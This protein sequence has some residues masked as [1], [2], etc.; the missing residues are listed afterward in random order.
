MEQTFKVGK[1]IPKL[2]K[3]IAAVIRFCYF[4]SVKIVDINGHEVAPF[5]QAE[6]PILLYISHRNGAL[7]G[8]VTQKL[9]ADAVSLVSIQL[10][11]HPILRYFF[12]GIPVIRDKDK[13]RYSEAVASIGNPIINAIKHVQVGGSLGIYP[14]GTSEWGYSHLP[15]H[16]GGAKIV[17][18]L[19]QK[20]QPLLVYAVGLFYQQPN[21]FR[22]EVEVVVSDAIEIVAKEPEESNQAWEERIFEQLNGT[23]DKVSVHCRD[24]GH[25]AQVSAYASYQ[26]QTQ[27]GS[28]AKHFIE[29]QQAVEL[30]DR[31]QLPAV[32]VEKPSYLTMLAV[33]IFMLLWIP[34]LCVAKLA[35]NKAD[36][37]NTVSFFRVIAGALVSLVW[38]PLL[39][40]ELYWLPLP[41]AIVM[42]IFMGWGLCS[43]AKV[44]RYLLAKYLIR[45]G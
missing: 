25:F 22:S 44:R 13:E 6:R 23:L 28:Y 7:D 18:K 12:Y 39:L 9:H 34:V 4:D 8:Y 38:L 31:E 21:V 15:Y 19:L 36:A 14:E 24:E 43:Y 42:V 10:T 33:A 5:R 27:G 17:K 30:P 29:A 1:P 37:I 35:G 3:W 16:N 41:V 32:K 26:Y 11:Q 2:Q 40:I 20:Q 45:L